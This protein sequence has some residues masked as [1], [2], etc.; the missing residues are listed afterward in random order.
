MVAHHLDTVGIV[1]C[2]V[3]RASLFSEEAGLLREQVG[4]CQVHS[5]APQ[6]I[7]QQRI[8]RQRFSPFLPR[9]PTINGG[10]ESLIVWYLSYSVEVPNPS[11]L[12][13]ASWL[14]G[15]VLNLSA[16]WKASG[17]PP[18]KLPTGGMQIPRGSPC[19]GKA[20]P[21]LVFYMV[22]LPKPELWSTIRGLDSLPGAR[23]MSEGFWFP[24]DCWYKMIGGTWRFGY[25][26]TLIHGIDLDIS[27]I[28]QVLQKGC[29]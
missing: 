7:Y 20:C 5:W 1:T 29:I 15:A 8:T 4:S 12:S 6:F 17:Q 21:Y 11:F 19:L 10:L 14:L 25:G 24:K 3:V 22:T 28:F 9:K 27:R 2:A 13:T 23:W 18:Q 16:I 26:L